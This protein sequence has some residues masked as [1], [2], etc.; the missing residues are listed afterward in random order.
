M[1]DIRLLIIDTNPMIYDGILSFIFNSVENMDRADMSIDFVAINNVEIS[2]RNRIKKMDAGL[3][4]LTYRARNPLKYIISLAKLIKKNQ[5]TVIHVHGSSCIM[6]IEL[7]AARIAG[8]P[9]CPHSH[10]TNCQHIRIHY[11]LR[12]L[13]LLLYKHGFACGEKA[14]EWIYGK[15]KFD[16]IK[17][18]IGLEK[19][20][21]SENKRREYRK[22]YGLLPNDVGIIH[23]AHFTEV[24][25][26]VFMINVLKKV[27]E[28][29]KH[30]KLLLVGQGKLEN[31]I[32]EKVRELGLQENVVFVGITQKVSQLLS[33]C[34][35]MVLPS[36]YEGFP[37]TAIEAQASGI[38][39]IF[40]DAVTRE[41]ELSKN[42]TYLELDEELWVASILENSRSFDRDKMSAQNIQN[43]K[44]SG[45]DIEKSVGRLKGLYKKYGK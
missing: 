16:I 8:V 33:A 20:R 2:I 13:F 11:L 41:C 5:Y 17:N 7:L 24:K 35:V 43:I 1:Q 36:L 6:A 19:Y 45:Y 21:Y 25:N 44:D 23:I 10:N 9:C 15:K 31:P 14:G 12:P 28:V 22:I 29:S 30:Y 26:H 18:G 40:S 4:I 39:C 37:F 3:Y 32:K 42:I 34:D 38:N 27:V